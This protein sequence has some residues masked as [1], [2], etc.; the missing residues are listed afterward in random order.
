MITVSL[1]DRKHHHVWVGCE[2]SSKEV[3]KQS[4]ELQI[5]FIQVTL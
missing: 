2:I 3:G 4:S 1:G 5:I